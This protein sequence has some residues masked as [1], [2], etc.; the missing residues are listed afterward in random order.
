[1]NCHITIHN[2]DNRI[3]IRGKWDELKKFLPIQSAEN[4]PHES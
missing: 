1:M 3:S 4:V 2:K